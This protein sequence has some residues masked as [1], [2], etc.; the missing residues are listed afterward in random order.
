MRVSASGY[1][2]QEVHGLE[3]QVAG[4]VEVNFRLRPASEVWEQG[5]YGSIFFPESESVL[6][7]YGPDVDTSRYGA[8]VAARGSQGALEST[9][10]Q[11]ISPVEVSELP[12]PGRDVY[13]MLARQGVPLAAKG[14]AVGVRVEVRG[15]INRSLFADVNGKRIYVCCLG[16]IDIIKKNP[17]KIIKQIEDKGITLD[18]TPEPEENPTRQGKK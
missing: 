10:S 6:T 7:F 16:C 4:R 18:K 11:V 17:A 14:F 2:G 9:V 3:V 15:K 8:F 5:R 13:T 12:F 1:Q